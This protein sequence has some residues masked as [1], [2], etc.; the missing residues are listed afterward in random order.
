MNTRSAPK[1]APGGLAA[2]PDTR[3]DSTP[4]HDVYL[5]YTLGSRL[6]WLERHEH[7]WIREVRRHQA[8]C[9]WCRRCDWT[10]GAV[11]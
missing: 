8:E 7:W 10:P 6:A 3:S 5:S 1:G 4:D 11:A 2:K 9:D